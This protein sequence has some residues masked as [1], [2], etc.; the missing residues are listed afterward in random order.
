M[1]TLR[2]D[3]RAGDGAAS[4]VDLYQAALEMAVWS[5]QHGAMAIVLSEHHG[6]ADGYLPTPMI[7]ATA[8]AA[9]TKRIPIMIAA[10]ILPLY[11]PVR[12]V[13][14]MNVLDI[15]SKGR[16]SY[17]F[18]VGYRAEEFEHFGYDFSQRGRVADDSL[19]LVL[20]LLRGE[21][22]TYRGRRVHITPPSTT[23]NGPMIMWGG[24]SKAAAD[25]AGRFGLGFLAQSDGPG[26]AEAYEASCRANGHEPGMTMF[27][28]KDT[29]SVT[30]VA[31]DVDGA[32]D[33][34][35]PYLLHD[36]RGYA[37]WNPDSETSAGISHA[38]TVE[39]LRRDY[40]SHQILTPA[41]ASAQITSGESLV[42]SPVC[43]GLPP[44]IG[45]SYLQRAMSVQR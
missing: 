8:L 24:A 16:V 34:I 36:A 7:L 18:C 28:S 40:R 25:R 10:L 17:V 22:I 5:E 44:Q 37:E 20:D 13:E 43:G 29:A 11:D 9:R 41:E 31:D 35:G 15:I 19:A 2:F 39:Q 23:S 42:L 14:E 4:S 45:W 26:L 27:P 33:E 32:W 12:L 38:T 6:S 21:P 1:I 30:F 3:M